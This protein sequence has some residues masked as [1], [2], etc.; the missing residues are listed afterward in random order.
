MHKTIPPPSYTDIEDDSIYTFVNRYENYLVYESL[1]LENRTYNNVEQTT[2]IINALR[3]DT[4]L[5]PGLS[6]VESS[7]QAYQRDSRL[8]PAITFP[9]ELE[10]DEI[11]IIIDEHSEDYACGEKST[12]PRSIFNDNNINGIVYTF[13]I[14]RSLGKH[15]TPYRKKERYDTRKIDRRPHD[16]G[17]RPKGK[18][19]VTFKACLG[20]GHCVTQ[21]DICYSLA[22]ATICQE[23]ISN[24]LND[25]VTKKNAT[26]FKTNVVRKSIRLKQSHICGE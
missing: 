4:R 24:K 8:N 10:F 6:Y 26:D 9:L 1:S 12:L 22:K 23:F 5:H 14:V 21:G 3:Q 19:N 20:F 13:P 7:L 16:D 2:F 11:A 25:T 17:R 18:P 15:T